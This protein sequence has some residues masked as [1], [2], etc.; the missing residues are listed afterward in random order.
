MRK[1]HP[2]A[3]RGILSTIAISYGIPILQTKS[4]ED[5]AELIRSIARREQNF[6][7][8]E[9][10]IRT[11]T[12]PQTTKEQQEFII[13]SLPGIGPSLAKSLLNEFGSVKKIINSKHENLIKIDQLGNKKAEEII[14]ILN[15]NYLD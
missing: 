15:E 13:E 10:G 3:I 1:I 4:P 11:E 7:E 5:T 6:K 12:K 14:K 2:N 8:K 9:F